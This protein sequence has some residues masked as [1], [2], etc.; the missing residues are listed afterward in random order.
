MTKI[1]PALI[2][3][4]RGDD[5]GLQIPAHPEALRAGGV[6]FLTKAFQTFG[7]LAADNRVTR[8]TRFEKCDG[9]STGQKL[10]LSIEYAKPAP[11][12]HTDLFVKFSRD[13]TD[14]IRDARGKVEMVTEIGFAPITRQPGFPINVP[15]AYF[16]DFH[17][18]SYTG[19]VITQRIPFGVGAIEPHRKKAH[20]HELPDVL[21]YYSVVMQALGRIAGAHRAGR[22][23]SDIARRFPYDPN[24]RAV[25]AIPHGADKIRTLIAEY[26][27]Y[28]A[29]APQLL[30]ANIRTSEFIAKLEH[31]ALRFLKH[32]KDTNRFLNSNPDL[33]ALCHWNANIDNAWFYRDDKNGL[34]CGLI[35]WGHVNVMN[36]SFP[37]WGSL[38]AARYQT[39]NQHLDA[40]LAI[41]LGEIHANGGPKIDIAELKLHLAMYMGHM[42]TA[43][44]IAS[45]GRI[46]FRLPEAIHATGPDDPLLDKSETANN[47]V[48]IM[49]S[50]LNFWQTQ[51]FGA[52]L[53]RALARL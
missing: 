31:D 1:D 37:I 6:D 21:E 36:L 34:H 27:D 4:V 9:G 19:F 46:L 52:C 30:P 5:T 10:F 51:D 42:G 15:V 39:W 14:P 22:L 17:R 11:D 45:P 38:S 16:A 43:Y 48:T 53:D 40:L 41:F 7:A 13:F 33:I 2:D 35:D 50:C 29:K 8:I 3:F 26:A 24:G 49:S 25:E 28:A 47:Q 12:L 23:S 44:F 32:E 20:D 18:E